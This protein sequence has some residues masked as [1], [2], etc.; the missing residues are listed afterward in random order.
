MPLTTA[1]PAIWRGVTSPGSS[2]SWVHAVVDVRSVNVAH[3]AVGSSVVRSG[4]RAPQAADEVEGLGRD[5]RSILAEGG[6]LRVVEFVRVGG[7]ARESSNRARSP[8]NH[9]RR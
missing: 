2:K 9:R 8:Q 3:A 4:I 7:V 1:W 6:E 5:G